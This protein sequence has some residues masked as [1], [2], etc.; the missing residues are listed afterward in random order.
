MV[1]NLD[2]DRNLRAM[3]EL[4]NSGDAHFYLKVNMLSINK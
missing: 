2:S 3:K 4:K 1:L